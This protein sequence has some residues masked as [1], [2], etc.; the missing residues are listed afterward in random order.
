MTRLGLGV[1]LTLLVM[2]VTGCS[3][4]ADEV[5]DAVGDLPG[6]ISAEPSCFEFQCTVEIEAERDATAA[7]LAAM[8]AAART[9]DDAHDIEVAL[10][11]DAP[12]GVSARLEVDTSPA[13]EDA[14]I[15]SLLAWAATAAE[16]GLAGLEVERGNA[17][18]IRVSGSTT[19]G[20]SAWPLAREAWSLAD[21]L[22]GAE[23]AFTR[24]EQLAQQSLRISDSFPADAVAVAEEIE[25]GDGPVTGVAITDD[26]FLVGAISRGAAE[27]LRSKLRDEPRLEGRSVEVVVSTNVLAA[28]A[29]QEPGTSQ[30]LEPILAVLDDQPAVL[31]A[32]IAG[33]S[34]E[35]QVD[36]LRSAPALVER[37]RRRAGAAFVDTTLV[38]IDEPGGRLEITSEGDDAALDL[39][40]ALLDTPG[41]VDLTLDQEV[42]PDP[43]RAA[44]GLWLTVRQPGKGTGSAPPVGAQVTRIAR[45]LSSTPGTAASYALGVTVEDVDGRSASA[46]WAVERT[47]TGLTLG[48]VDGTPER[49]AEITAAWARGAR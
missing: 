28:A 23:M 38:L 39:A 45:I 46:G 8:L 5:N 2:S 49:Q 17:E 11:W 13:A 44:V 31:F 6:V 29:A 19:D 16:D 43:D 47:S 3:P 35:M 14:P 26:R 33:S 9:V 21:G 10:A 12:G 40:M 15:G 1:L 25:T 41:L 42:D 27:D 30:R 7:E 24:P 4:S 18:R 48:E 20:A 32:T 22:A 34:V 36:S 37:V